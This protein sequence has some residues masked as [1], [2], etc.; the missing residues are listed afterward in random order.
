MY[1]FWDGGVGC[2]PVNFLQ[3]CFFLKDGVWVKRRAPARDHLYGNGEM[4]FHTGH[5]NVEDVLN[6][7]DGLMMDGG[8]NISDAKNVRGLNDAAFQDIGHDNMTGGPLGGL[9]A[10][11][12]ARIVG[13]D[14]VLKD[15]FFFI[16]PEK[17]LFEDLAAVPYKIY[18]DGDHDQPHKIEIGDWNPFMKQFGV[19]NFGGFGLHDYRITNHLVFSSNHYIDPFSET[20]VCQ[21]IGEGKFLVQPSLGKF[22]EIADCVPV[23]LHP[24]IPRATRRF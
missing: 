14:G 18:A 4:F 24:D 13:V 7:V 12:E 20:D 5:D 8:D 11:E 9:C 23:Y 21:I 3:A 6:R 2:V 16:H 1:L 19:D 15:G 22:S 10:S 17:C